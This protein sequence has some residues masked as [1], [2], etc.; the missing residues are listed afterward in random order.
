MAVE[1]TSRKFMDF[2][3]CNGMQILK[4]MNG[5]KLFHIQPIRCYK[6]WL[7][8]QQVFRFVAGNFRY[9]SEHMTQMSSCPFQTVTMVNLPLTGFFVHRKLVQIVVKVRITGTQIST[10]Q[11]G[12]RSENSCDVNLPC[13][14]NNQGHSSLPFMELCNDSGC[15][16]AILVSVLTQAPFEFDQKLADHVAENDGIVGFNVQMGNACWETLNWAYTCSD[17]IV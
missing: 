9:R 15:S 3:F 12:M 5:R 13:S 4:F 11:C 14:Q 10:E 2:L 16:V 6:I 7:P 17:W 8:F 1:M